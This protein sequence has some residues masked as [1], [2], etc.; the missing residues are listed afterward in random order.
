MKIILAFLL[1]F[2]LSLVIAFLILAFLSEPIREQMYK[3]K[4]VH[5]WS[6]YDLLGLLIMLYP[7]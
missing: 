6:E 4:P 3:K 2:L 5:T 7:V 1:S